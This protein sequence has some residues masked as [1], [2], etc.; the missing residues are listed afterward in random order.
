[1]ARKLKT[2]QT[3]QGFYDFAIAVP[4][5]KTALEAWGAN[6]NLFHRGFAEESRTQRRWQQPKPGVALKRPVGTNG[7]FDEESELLTRS[8]SREAASKV[9]SAEAVSTPARD[10]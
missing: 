2:Y 9:K 8:R 6:S 5:M 7:P 3:S 4:S 1:M 10:T